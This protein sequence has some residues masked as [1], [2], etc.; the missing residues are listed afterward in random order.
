MKFKTI[1]LA[2]YE[3]FVNETSQK[4][5]MEAATGFLMIQ[6]NFVIHVVEVKIFNKKLTVLTK[7][8]SF[9]L[10]WITYSLYIYK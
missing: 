3:S 2:K 7:L 9:F 4:L 10:A 1:K 8:F 5:Q 6:Q